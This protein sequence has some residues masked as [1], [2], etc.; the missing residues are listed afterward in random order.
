[1]GAWNHMKELEMNPN[2]AITLKNKE[3]IGLAVAAQIP[4]RYCTLYHTEAAKLNGATDQEIH[5][6][7]AYA[8]ITRQ[9]SAIMNGTNVERDTFRKDVEKMVEHI[10]ANQTPPQVQGQPPKKDIS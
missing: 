1:M 4:C 5:E 10:K 3:L 9:W 6:S 2:T 7:V 8:G